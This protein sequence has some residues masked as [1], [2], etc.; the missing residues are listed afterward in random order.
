MNEETFIQQIRNT[1]K[2]LLAEQKKTL[3]RLAEKKLPLHQR[4]HINGVLNLLDVITDFIDP[5]D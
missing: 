1:D 4:Q 5:I 3:V 2:E